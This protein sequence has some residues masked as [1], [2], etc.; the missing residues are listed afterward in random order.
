MPENTLPSFR[1]AL[2]E[3]ATHI[4]LDIHESKDGEIV[5]LH[6]DSLDR[7]TDGQGRVQEMGIEALKRLDAGYRMSRGQRCNLP[8]PRARCSHTDLGGV[9]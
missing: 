8:L 1:R 3:G 9:L 7:T 6:D 2:E 5:V 4:E